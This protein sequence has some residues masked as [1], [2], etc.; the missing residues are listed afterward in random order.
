M[1]MIPDTEHGSRI[2]S[3][4]HMSF[5]YMASECFAEWRNLIGQFEVRI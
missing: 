4:N 3:K 2:D 1:D 5:Y